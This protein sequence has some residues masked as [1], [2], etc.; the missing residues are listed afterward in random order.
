[1]RHGLI[2]P[3]R[4]LA[5]AISCLLALSLLCS[6]GSREAESRDTSDA[7]LSCAQYD[8]AAV[9]EH[10]S[11]L[12]LPGYDTSGLLGASM[13]HY[14]PM[15]Q[16]GANLLYGAAQTESV[17][18]VILLAP[19]H[20]GTGAGI[21][22]SG[23]GYRWA[24]GSVEGDAASAEY[25]KAL[26]RVDTAE[27][28]RILESEYS[29]SLWAPYIRAIFPEARVVTILFT[30]SAASADLSAL[31]R[32]ILALSEEKSVFVLASV[33]F[34][35]YQTPDVMRE[36]DEVTRE[37]VLRGDIPALR[38]LDGTYLD[39][40]EALCVLMM[41]GGV[42]ELD[43]RTVNYTENARLYGASYFFYG[44]QRSETS[45]DGTRNTAKEKESE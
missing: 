26:S 2:P 22:L 4:L 1:M 42:R 15:M 41:S 10:L 5:G 21:E 3:V 12:E 39:C 44:V 14:V 9:S 34:S 37:T 33:D 31:S 30:R 18:T 19:N 38:R 16:Y 43:Y 35:H 36:H 29:A 6:C 28:I 40:P 20:E 45:P 11:Q 25:L 32:A 8:A 23:L 24:D 17:E 13:P 27:D 7:Y